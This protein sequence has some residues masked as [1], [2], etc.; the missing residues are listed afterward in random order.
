[1]PAEQSARCKPQEVPSRRTRC[2]AKGLLFA[3]AFVW[4][5]GG[6][7]RSE[8]IHATVEAK[9]Q[10]CVSCHRA[11]LAEAKSPTHMGVFPDS[12]QSCH[13]T[14]RWRPAAL[15]DHHWYALNDKHATT[16]CAGC[17]TGQPA[18]YAGTPTECVGCHLSS[19]QNAEHP[20]HVG[21]LAETCG[22][23]HSTKGWTPATLTDHPWFPLKDRHAATPCAGCHTGQP[24]R[25]AGTPTECAGCHLSSFQS[26]QHPVHVGVLAQTCG[27]CHSSKAWTPAT[28]T[29]HPWFP[30][31]G[32]HLSTP[33][34]SCHTGTPRQFAGT[35]NQCVGCHLADYQR[36][37]FPGHNAFPQTCRDCHNTGAW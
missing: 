1:M 34:I 2:C 28:V 19:F 5:L 30:L 35:S 22:G 32:K 15:P 31:D 23:C 9:S 36:S 24:A 11:A 4:A 8:D 29:E 20:V 26:A 18:R 14:D 27:G 13:T 12:C 21:V 3:S 6:C 16:P 37:T 25:Y 7:A 10:A 33:C 17:H